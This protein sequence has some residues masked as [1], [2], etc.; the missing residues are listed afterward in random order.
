MD[1][2]V[3]GYKR[4]ACSCGNGNEPSDPIQCWEI[5]EWLCKCW[6]RKTSAQWSLVLVIHSSSQIRPATSYAYSALLHTHTGAV[7]T[8]PQPHKANQQQGS[9]L[10]TR[11]IKSS[12]SRHFIK[13]IT[14]HNICTEENLNGRDHFDDRRNECT[15][16]TELL[17]NV[18]QWPTVTKLHAHDTGEIIVDKRHCHLPISAMGLKASTRRAPAALSSVGRSTGI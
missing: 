5:T 7:L 3:S 1:W 8:P 16:R 11:T 13:W 2:C 15:R 10:H 14:R 4:V 12:S 18:V 9:T 6:I 17:Q